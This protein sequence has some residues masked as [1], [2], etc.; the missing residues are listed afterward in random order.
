MAAVCDPGPA[1]KFPSSPPLTTTDRPDSMAS[2]KSL[3]TETVA[4]TERFQNESEDDDSLILA[5]RALRLLEN[6]QAAAT[7][8]IQAFDPK[9]NLHPDLVRLL[10]AAA[11]R[12]PDVAQGLIELGSSQ[13][14]HLIRRTPSGSLQVNGNGASRHASSL[15][16][17]ISISSL[18]S[19]ISESS[20]RRSN[21]ASTTSEP[22]KPN[23]KRRLSVLSTKKAAEA[24]STTPP[25]RKEK[26][27][28]DSIKKICKANLKDTKESIDKLDRADMDDETL[29][30]DELRRMA[31][32]CLGH[33]TGKFAICLALTL[34][35]EKQRWEA[36]QYL[37]ETMVDK[38]KLLLSV[39]GV[40]GPDG[41]VGLPGQDGFGIRD[42]WVVLSEY[43]R[44]RLATEDDSAWPKHLREVA[45]ISPHHASKAWE[46]LIACEKIQEA[47]APSQR[48]SV[49]G[50][51]STE[52]ET[53]GQ[54][55]E[56]SKAVTKRPAASAASPQEITD[57]WAF[58]FDLLDEEA[59]RR[60]FRELR[61]LRQLFNAAQV[62]SATNRAAN[63]K[64]KA[65]KAFDLS[66]PDDDLERWLDTKWAITAM[67]GFMLS[68][69]GIYNAVGETSYESL[70]RLDNAF[71][72][73]FWGCLGSGD[74]KRLA[75]EEGKQ[76]VTDIM[77]VFDDRRRHDVMFRLR[78][79]LH[80]MQANM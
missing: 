63:L 8:A 77:K 48:S 53:E 37:M 42:C 80:F 54:A 49:E 13:N 9:A 36:V 29:S 75:A 68:K 52:T 16:H 26:I 74:H 21:D 19:S 25:R 23:L 14:G 59:A 67:K 17:E 64:S 3:E 5:I 27:S 57:R 28:M 24:Q 11:V 12:H 2:F 1:Q 72:K 34:R 76:W 45:Q 43:E 33:E 22:A 73:T 51:D 44:E 6:P 46:I 70:D 55:G 32:E 30:N 61:L 62:P 47:L 20:N 4:A 60:C 71:C 66:R 56:S 31:E 10:V 18:L 35:D 79:I 65:K 58:F 69:A 50:R 7:E 41:D 78:D 40:F 38:L 15:V 39:K